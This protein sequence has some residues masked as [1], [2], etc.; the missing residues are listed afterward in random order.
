MSNYPP[1]PG[2]NSAY[3]PPGYVPPYA[4]VVSPRPTSVTV[5]S[6][7]A[8]IFGSLGLL[9][10]LGGLVFQVFALATGGKNPFAPNAP[11]M[12][13]TAVVAYGT[14]MSVIRLGFCGMLLAGGIGGLKLQPWARRTMILWSL[15]LI[16]LATIN[17]LI[18][19]V[20]VNPV[21]VAHLK[22]V[23][24][25]TNPQAAQAL[26]S[27]LGPLQMVWAFIGWALE[28]ILPSCFLLLWRSPRVVAAFEPPPMAQGFQR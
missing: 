10:G 26:N 22:A 2:S 18:M 27:M 20:W 3:P 23:Q 14:V 6:I 4:S 15:A 13:D 5:M 17:L 1:P 11:V 7:L 24:R 21:T 16:A 25:Q 12:N 28:M 9:C 19:L 8:I